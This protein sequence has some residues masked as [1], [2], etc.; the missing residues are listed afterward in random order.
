MAFPGAAA[1]ASSVS[2]REVLFFH[3]GEECVMKGNV[4]NERHINFLIFGGVGGLGLGREGRGGEVFVYFLCF[5]V[6][7][8]G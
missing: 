5:F 8:R 2:T 4:D 6:L 3:F 7:L 1:A